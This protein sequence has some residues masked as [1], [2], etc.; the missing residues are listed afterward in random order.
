MNDF[1]AGDDVEI[2]FDDKTGETRSK[3]TY[4][5]MLEELTAVAN[6]YGF[7]INQWGTRASMARFYHMAC[8]PDGTW[9][10]D[11]LANDE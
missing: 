8:K 3:Q 11:F 9:K 1:E 2:V 7:D 4:D 6:K 5:L 10:M